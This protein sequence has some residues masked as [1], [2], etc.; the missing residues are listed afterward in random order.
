[1]DI[2]QIRQQYNAIDLDTLMDVIDEV[3]VRTLPSTVP[4][5]PIVWGLVVDDA[6]QPR[7]LLEPGAL[8][9]AARRAR[10]APVPSPPPRARPILVVDDSLTTRMLEQSILES[11]GYEVDTA[12]SAEEGLETARRRRYRLFLVDVEMPGMDGFSFV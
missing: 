10:I 7:P 4:V 9:A 5:D 6:G 8:V 3:V 11:A 1:M 12:T 2:P